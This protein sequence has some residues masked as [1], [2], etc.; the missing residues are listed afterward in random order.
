MLAGEVTRRRREAEAKGLRA[1]GLLP[2]FFDRRPLPWAG[3]YQGHLSRP[4]SAVPAR[5]HPGR[6]SR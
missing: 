3:S 5:G 4:D 1:L 2:D 6:D